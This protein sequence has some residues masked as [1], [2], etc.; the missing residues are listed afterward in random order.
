MPTQQV[1]R[2]GDLLKQHRG[3]AG[4]TQEELAEAARIGVRGLSDLER[5][6]STM[7]RATTVQLL[8]DALILLGAERAAFEAAARHAPPL[9]AVMEDV[10][11]PSTAPPNA[12]LNT[13]ASGRVSAADEQG[14]ATTTLTFLVADVRGYTAFTH[15]H[16]DAAGAALATR[17]TD[18]AYEAVSAFDG[19]VIE[20]WGDEVLAVF[21]SGRQ[22]V[23]AAV[24]LQARCATRT[25][26]D[27]P[28]FAGIGLDVGE[29]I[30]VGGGYRGEAINVA[31]RLCALAKAGEALAS[32][33]VVHVA[34]RIDGVIY[35]ARGAMALKGISA[36]TRVCSIRS[37]AA[38]AA[39]APITSG[40]SD[41]ASIQPD[42][43]C[44][45]PGS[46]PEEAHA[47]YPP[48]QSSRMESAMPLNNL[49]IP[50]TSFIGR[51]HEQ[52]DVIA[53]LTGSRLLTLTGAGGVGKTRLALQAAGEVLVN[54]RDGVWLVELAA[55]ADAA[56]V[57]QAVAAVLNVREEP[58]QPIVTTLVNY[59]KAGQLL[60][61]LDNCEHLIGACAELATTL[62]QQRPSIRLLATSREGLGV[63]GERLYRVP[64]LALP[65]PDRLL[66][67]ERLLAFSAVQL[68]V[69]R[70]R[71]R[72]SDF[73]LTTQNARAIVQI[74]VRLDGI[75]LAIELAAA[76][77]GVLPVEAIAARLDDRFRLLTTGLRTAVPRQQTLRATLEW[78][79]AL[80]STKEQTVLHRLS[81]FQGGWTLEAAEAVCTDEQVTADDFLG[82]L[83]GLADKSLVWVEEHDGAI[84]YRLLETIRHYAWEQLA[85]T[86]EQA[87]MQ[88]RHRDWFVALAKQG[89][90]AVGPAYE[91]WLKQLDA[92]QDNLREVLRWAMS[93]RSGLEGAVHVAEALVYFW[94]VRGLLQEGY[95][96]LGQL[97]SRRDQLPAEHQA[98]VL[99][100]LGDLLYC[101]GGYGEAVALFAEAVAIYRGLG[102]ARYMAKALR[103]QAT[104][105]RWHGDF[106]QAATCFSECLMLHRDLSDRPGIADA[107]CNMARAAR[108]QGE[109]AQSRSLLKECLLLVRTLD[110]R[111][112]IARLLLRLGIVAREFGDY[113]QARELQEESLALSRELGD[114]FN[115]ASALRQLGRVAREVGD[116]DRARAHYRQSLVLVRTLDYK[117][118]I[119]TAFEGLALEMAS[120]GNPQRAAQ[121]LGSAEALRGATGRA[122]LPTERAAYESAVVRLRA[123]LGDEAYAAANATGRAMPL[124]EAIAFALK[125]EPVGSSSKACGTPN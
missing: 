27:L 37:A 21:A 70:A 90:M 119:A 73:T 63:A 10:R 69:E 112:Q 124:E 19:R 7:P 48:M 18:L 116:H 121:L 99:S 102:D 41:Q 39:S 38:L 23:R 103:M 3:R 64:S 120:Q 6:V 1:W 49:P 65:N 87:T 36:P 107:L 91:M 92:E 66:S 8:A 40:R 68:L 12:A 84:R 123:M 51:E 22:A 80:L 98:R 45:T 114:K 32:E 53:L 72:R 30:S 118:G 82:L 5:G 50:L 105:A 95:T 81:V 59:L 34:R 100:A 78:S 74:C 17:F 117:G 54:Y 52:A 115:E 111:L 89:E 109:D 71:A 43:A 31:A 25:T 13:L 4:L 47:T 15:E 101:Q 28:L 2:F 125:E 77:V 79:Y 55:L 75:P 67:V 46:A 85:A 94:T 122:I 11:E 86:N 35:E 96:W 56:L 62:L 44:P 24:D 88:A 33:S 97:V 60:L 14:V 16:G 104:A 29:P 57:S 42:A 83:G 93:D 61:V 26:P 58:G 20:V 108:M 113:D 110:D 9:L 76:W 106:R